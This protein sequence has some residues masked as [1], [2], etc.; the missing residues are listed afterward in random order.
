MDDDSIFR[1]NFYLCVSLLQTFFTFCHL[2]TGLIA[3]QGKHLGLNSEWVY[4]PLQGTAGLFPQTRL[5]LKVT[6]FPMDESSPMASEKQWERGDESKIPVSFLLIL[7]SHGGFWT[8]KVKMFTLYRSVLWNWEFSIEMRAAFLALSF[9]HKG[10]EMQLS[11][12][13]KSLAWIGHHCSY[14]LLLKQDW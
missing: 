3:Y 13:W 11:F 10:Q 4:F 1:R 2:F 14:P 7:I 5:W 12:R 9:V 8:Y 6:C